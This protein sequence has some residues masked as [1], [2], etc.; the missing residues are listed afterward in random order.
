MLRTPA[1]LDIEYDSTWR[2]A[3]K[4]KVLGKGGHGSYS[5]T[6]DSS[7]MRRGIWPTVPLTH[8]GPFL[9]GFV[10]AGPNVSSQDVTWRFLSVQQAAFGAPS[11]QLP[12]AMQALAAGAANGK[13]ECVKRGVSESHS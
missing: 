13:E 5:T 4:V 1:V 3:Y 12:S 2:S 7:R 10:G 9:G 6:L 11:A 8:C